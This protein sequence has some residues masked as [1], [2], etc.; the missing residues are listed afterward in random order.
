M[1]NFTIHEEIQN[2]FAKLQKAKHMWNTAGACLTK[3]QLVAFPFYILGAA[4][5]HVGVADC[6]CPAMVEKTGSANTASRKSVHLQVC[7]YAFY[8]CRDLCYI[9]IFKGDG[10]LGVVVIVISN[11]CFSYCVDSR[12]EKGEQYHTICLCLNV[13]SAFFTVEVYS[14]TRIKAHPPWLPHASQDS[15]ILSCHC[16]SSILLSVCS[17]TPAMLL[18]LKL[19]KILENFSFTLSWQ[20]RAFLSGSVSLATSTQRI[21]VS[22]CL[23]CRY[24]CNVCKLAVPERCVTFLEVAAFPR[25]SYKNNLCLKQTW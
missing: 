9:C 18:T 22:H 1:W 5:I 7:K 23:H 14:F 21:P 16:F 17:S 10:E 6:S 19:L 15:G 3:T 25:V 20:F 13:L 12:S 4:T 24:C 2:A 11:R 8:G